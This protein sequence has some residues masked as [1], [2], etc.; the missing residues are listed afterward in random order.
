VETNTLID[1]VDADCDELNHLNH[2][3]AVRYLE[4]AR[5][6]WY[7]ACGLYDGMP[8]GVYE[9]SAVVVNINYNYASECFLGEQVSCL[10]RAVV[11][12]S[13]SFTLYHEIKKP[14]G[15]VAI[16]GECT[17]VIMGI[18]ARGIIPV[19]DCMAQHLPKR[20]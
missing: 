14:D 9:Q 8:E 16:H 11:M 3:V 12:G 5:E 6:D 13:K 1:V 2:V 4:D 17:S 15:T 18:S 7:R 10:S 19:P 20:K